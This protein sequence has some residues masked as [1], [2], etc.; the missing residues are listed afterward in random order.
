MSSGELAR[1]KDVADM[2][3]DAGYDVD[4][5]DLAAH[6]AVVGETPYALVACVEFDT[7]KSL[8]EHVFDVQGAL[9]RL[10]QEAPSARSWDLYVVALIL[11]PMSSAAERALAEMIEADTR[12]ARKFV[13]VAVRLPELDRALRPL[14]P[15]RPPAELGVGDPLIELREELLNLNVDQD[16]AERALAAFRQ[17]EEVEVP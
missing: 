15:L 8:D 4:V 3:R 1:A 9:T 11:A 10:A 17:N 16:V 7:W 13:R 12:Y 14:L 2:L 5:R 6:Q